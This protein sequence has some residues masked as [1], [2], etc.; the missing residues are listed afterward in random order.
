MV[1]SPESIEALKAQM[2]A[3][4]IFI[5]KVGPRGENNGV[6]AKDD[7]LQALVDTGVDTFDLIAGALEAPEG[8]QY[9][10]PDGLSAVLGKEVFLA[11]LNTAGKENIQ[12][13][14]HMGR[15]CP[16]NSVDLDRD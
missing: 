10:D 5:A 6:F 13:I 7:G 1:A 16:T 15:I 14:R 9:V 11:Y 3:G 12:H 4:N 2:H 8:V